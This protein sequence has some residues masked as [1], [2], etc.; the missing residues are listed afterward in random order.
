MFWNVFPQYTYDFLSVAVKY[1]ICNICRRL[2]LPRKYL[3]CILYFFKKILTSSD[4]STITIP[5]IYHFKQRAKWKH[6][7]KKLYIFVL[8]DARSMYIFI[9]T[10][11]TTLTN[12]AAFTKR[13]SK[14]S[15]Q[16]TWP[17]QL[18][19]ASTSHPVNLLFDLKQSVSLNFSF[20]CFIISL[21]LL[22]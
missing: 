18:K 6:T 14:K 16:N 11:D 20:R 8:D 12:I 4:F 3:N 2:Y 19:N 9:Q 13:A 7:Q 5:N 15:Q 10:L 1:I 17:C 22:Q 21:I